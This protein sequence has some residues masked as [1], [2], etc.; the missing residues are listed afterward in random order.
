MKHKLILILLAVF[1]PL[2]AFSTNVDEPP[3]KQEIPLNPVIEGN[4]EWIN[5]SLVQI[6]IECC[7]FGMMNS[8]VTTVWSDL[9]DVVLTVTNCSTGNVWYDS[10]DS[11]LEPQT[12]LTLSGEPGIYQ[13]VYITESGGVYEGTFTIQ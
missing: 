1:L 13:I 7:Y 4:S 5:R 10:F 12:V 2:S 6:P 3:H 8:L 11:A 9:G